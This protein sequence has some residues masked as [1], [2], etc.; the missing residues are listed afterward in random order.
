[1]NGGGRSGRL[2]PVRASYDTVALAYTAALASELAAKPLDRALLGAFAEQVRAVPGVDGR[3]WDVGCGPGHVAGYLAGLGVRAAGIDLSLQMVRQARLRHPELAF[4]CGSMTEL[5][6]ASGCWAG[7][8]SFY[9]V[10]HLV[11]D[12][13]LAAALR[14]FRRVLADGGLLLIAV[15]V[16]DQ[17]S[18][19]YLDQ[20]FGLA[21]DL[22]ARFFVADWLAGQVAKAGF[23]IEAAVQRSP[24]PDAE[25]PTKRLYLL[26]RASRHTGSP[27]RSR[28]ISGPGV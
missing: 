7:L 24:Y 4:S 27:T 13:D 10:I 28:E 23:V 3:V 2:A 16:D 22:T 11:D 5:P 17:G 14:E 19:T 8:V 6:S 20:F 26:A 15:H 21:V 12:D 18:S 9:S 1:M 25:V